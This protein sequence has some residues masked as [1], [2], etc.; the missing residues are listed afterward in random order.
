MEKKIRDA[1]FVLFVCTETYLR[2]VMKEET[3]GRG[4]A[5]SG[6]PK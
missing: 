1:K 3:P 4:S 5:S 6:S 2:R